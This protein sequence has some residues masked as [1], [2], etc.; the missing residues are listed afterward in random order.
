[1]HLPSAANNCWSKAQNPKHKRNGSC[2]TRCAGHTQVPG[3]VGSREME[4]LACQLELRFTVWRPRGAG[5]VFALEGAAE[6][7]T[8]RVCLAAT[9]VEYSSK[10]SSSHLRWSPDR[11]SLTSQTFP[12]LS[13]QVRGVVSLQG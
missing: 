1:M 5:V 12:R 3:P 10:H 11:L 7:V 4:L 6:A 8:R 2:R 13:L 9:G